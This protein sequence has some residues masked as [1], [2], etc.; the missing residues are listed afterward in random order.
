MALEWMSKALCA[1]VGTEMFFPDF[2]Q[3][4]HHAKKVCSRCDVTNECLQYA[5]SETTIYGVWGGTTETDRRR[6]KRNRVA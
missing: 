3:T 2:G 1:E 5:L 4:P 6:M